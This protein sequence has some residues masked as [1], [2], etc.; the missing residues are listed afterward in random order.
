MLAGIQKNHAVA[1]VFFNAIAVERL[2]TLLA[3]N[4]DPDA[5]FLKPAE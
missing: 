4:D 2:I 3:G 5:L 1:D